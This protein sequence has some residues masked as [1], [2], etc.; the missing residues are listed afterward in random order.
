MKK[1]ETIKATVI[2]KRSSVS[3]LNTVYTMYYITF[4]TDEGLRLEFYVDGDT[5]GKIIIGDYGILSYKKNKFM[6]FNIINPKA[7]DLN[8]NTKLHT[9]VMENN[10]AEAKILLEKGSNVNAS[11][12]YN[13]TPLLLAIENNNIEMVK[14]LIKYNCT[15][16]IAGEKNNSTII[17]CIPQ[18]E[19]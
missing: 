13:I 7:S 17:N 16:N 2:N 9:A 15:C 12:I 14:L 8:G 10:I 6:G 11:N 3:G 1:F 4:Q 18:S 19:F 5:S